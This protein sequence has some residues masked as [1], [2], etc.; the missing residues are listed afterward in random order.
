MIVVPTSRAE[1]IRLGAPHYFTGVPCKSG[2]V[3]RRLTKARTCM[4]CARMW[5][6]RYLEE[7]PNKYREK[8]AARCREKM[9]AKMREARAKD[10]QKHR[11]RSNSWFR[12]NPDRA[13]A[14]TMKRH[15][16]KRMATPAWAD[17]DAIADVCSEAVRLQDIT[18]VP[19]DV[20]HV[21]PLKGKTVCGLHVHTNLRAIPASENRRKYNKMMEV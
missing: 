10:P 19:Y 15:A 17:H 4:A 7:N 2:H 12:R 21:I 8:W 11:D 9:A 6:A 5:Q 1:A 3:E 16:I 13:R 20:D 18:G 14:Y